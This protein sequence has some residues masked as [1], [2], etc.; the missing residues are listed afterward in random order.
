MNNLHPNKKARRNRKRLGRGIGSCLGG[1]SGR[2]TKGQR[3]RSSAVIPAWFEGGQTPLY[4]RVPK[5]GFTN[6]F[7]QEWNILNIENLIS[8][9]EKIG[10]NK[11]ILL[12]D[13][14]KSGI[15]NK[16]K[17]PVKLLAGSVESKELDIQKLKGKTISI[18]YASKKATE[19]VKSAGGTLKIEPYKKKKF[20]KGMSVSDPSTAKN[21][22]EVRKESKSKSK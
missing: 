7:R 18:N 10:N 19:L 9:L 15:V 22:S 8:A 6:I 16:K 21:P 13:I 14:S 4:R 11:E 17:L 3:S 20:K 5:R 2:G 12:K 1:T